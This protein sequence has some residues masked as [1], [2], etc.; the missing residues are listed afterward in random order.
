MTRPLAVIPLLVVLGGLLATAG[1][2]PDPKERIALL[3]DENQQLL[4]E[5][6]RARAEGQQARSD[7]DLCEQELATLRTDSA[8]LRRQL[9]D[10][11][12]KPPEPAAPEGWTSIPGGAMI[13]LDSEVL[14][15]S[16]K[17]DLRPEAR[18][19]LDR[20]VRVLNS[21]YAARDVLIYGHTDDERIK[22]SGWKDNFELSAQR[23]LSVAR[24]LQS[25]GVAP[26]RLVAG[27]CGEHRPI[28][29]NASS[30]NR[31]KNRRV[32][33]YVLDAVVQSASR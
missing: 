23:A 2:G 25:R 28:V 22:K 8:D 29:P 16:G 6:N 19:S 26:T 5:F 11:R 33:V 21:E 32:E 3:E 30:A 20:I 17:A 27:G 7:C 4:D 15:R 13:A 9:A 14:F 12:S 18:A 31:S 1:C 24:Y 10:A